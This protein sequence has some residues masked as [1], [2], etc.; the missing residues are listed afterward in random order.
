MLL[1]PPYS[2][3]FSITV[4]TPK[5]FGTFGRGGLAQPGRM[6]LTSA[7]FAKPADPDEVIGPCTH[8]ANSRSG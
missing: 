7:H 2:G 6:P 8:E 3:G 4:N 1:L 5:T